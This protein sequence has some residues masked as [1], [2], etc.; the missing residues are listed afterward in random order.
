MS[1]HEEIIE[2]WFNK[3]PQEYWWKKDDSFDQRIKDKF[4]KVHLSASMGETYSWRM[5]AHG[6]LAEIIVLDQF[7]RNMFRNSSESFK[8]DSQALVLSQEAIH[9][10]CQTHLTPNQRSFLY[11]PFMHSESICIQEKSMEL[12]SEKGLEENYGFAKRHYEIIKQ[13]GRFPHR[14][15]ILGRISTSEEKE[16]LTQPN[17]SF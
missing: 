9:N 3:T 11:M 14:N 16:F 17:S 4:S 12:Y 2:F 1:G 7:S 8:Y 13:F 10:N 6:R 15:D 5:S